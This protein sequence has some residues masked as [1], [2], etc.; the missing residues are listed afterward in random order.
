M[1]TGDDYNLESGVEPSS[2]TPAA[3]AAA[4]CVC[5]TLEKK[6]KGI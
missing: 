1:F 4:V 6:W 3:A 2:K 5:D